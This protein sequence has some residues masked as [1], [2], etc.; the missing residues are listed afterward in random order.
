MTR[1]AHESGHTADTIVAI[2][3][4]PGAGAVGIVRLSGS[5]ARRIAFQLFRASAPSFS[6]F[7]PRRLHHGS[8]VDR[9]GRVLDEILAA[10][11]PGPASFTGEDVVELFCHGGPALLRAALEEC[12]ARGARLAQAGE[13]SLRAF[14]NGKL[15]LT[16]A[17][18][19]AETIAAPTRQALHLAQM[20]L[21]GALGQRIQAM[22]QRLEDLR[23]Q[24]CLAVDFPDEDVECL[25]RADL[26]V[27]A[28][29]AGDEAARLLAS[30]ERAK[31]WREGVM[32]VLA[33]PVNAGKSSLMNALVGRR[34]A[35]VSPTPGTTR[36]YLEEP[37]DL[38]G[39][40]V[41]L[42]DTAGLR[43][44]SPDVGEVEAQGQEL[45]REFMA[46]AE[47]VLYVLDA[48]RPVPDESLDEL[49]TLDPARILVVL[50]K[51]DLGEHDPVLAQALQGRGFAVARISART[52]QG[53]EDLAGALRGLVLSAREGVEPDPGELAP[54]ARQAT[55]LTQA[56]LELQALEQD[57][58]AG[59]PY[60]IL[61]V[62]LEAACRI[63]SE[64][65]GHI[66]PQDVLDSI[67][68]RFCIGK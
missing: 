67:F 27:C 49:L 2:A 54:N 38:D 23:A 34:R 45:A 25:P 4:A 8:L 64:I 60:D 56:R 3:T 58:A 28:R 55:L 30:V 61:G 10:Y 35:L 65:T 11:M 32:A 13:F 9:Q 52:G 7:S 21:S 59:L 31:A 62:R 36:D 39:L 14:L 47:G 57:T 22:R 42:V 17:E 15:D 12:L 20:K 18:A 66:A 33:G 5:Q 68:S 46:R 48:S 1:A 41:R 63:L 43:G 26:V 53:V 19:I 29:E 24:L 44:N 40:V 37:L 16:Q 50:N 6:D 51:A